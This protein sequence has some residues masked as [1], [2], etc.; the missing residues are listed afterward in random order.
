MEQAAFKPVKKQS[1]PDAIFLQ[2]WGQIVDGEMEPGTVLPSERELSV[3]LKV[4]RQAVREALKRLEQARLVTIQQGGQTRVLNFLE[5]A[6][7]DVLGA[8]LLTPAGGLRVKVIRS[9]V[10]MRAVLAPDIAR[11]AA[12]RATKAHK[13]A[14]LEVVARMP[15]APQDLAALQKHSMAF[16]ATLVEASDNVAYRLAFNSLWETYAHV[17]EALLEPLR[18][19]LTAHTLYAAIQAAVR[20]GDADTAE[21]KA[22]ALIKRGTDPLMEMVDGLHAMEGKRP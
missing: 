9:V 18:E 12:L 4:N 20:D 22:R 21:R 17:K 8:L 16:W 14:L 19:E 15:D 2:L 1:L 3:L 5:T 6:G 7:T 10:E 11:L 13:K